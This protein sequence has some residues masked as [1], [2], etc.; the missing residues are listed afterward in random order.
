MQKSEWEDALDGSG[1]ARRER[2]GH[3][4]IIRWFLG[5]CRKRQPSL[6]P[7]RDAANEFD[8]HLRRTRQPSRW[9]LE[10]W[11][12]GLRWLLEFLGESG[13]KAAPVAEGGGRSDRD[14]SWRELMVVKLRQKHLSYR[15]EQTYLE[16][17]S[18]FAGFLTGRSPLAATDEDAVEFLHVM[19]KPG[20]G[21][22]S[23]LDG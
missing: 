20:L 8:R 11:R 13:L 16:W 15:T 3:R 12:T 1:L 5:Y 22:R 10:Q 18:R 19:R 17:I 9:Q 6:R 2:E 14:R 21:V 4:R 7:G 23:P